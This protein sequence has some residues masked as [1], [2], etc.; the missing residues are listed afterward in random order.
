MIWTRDERARMPRL[1]TTSPHLG[2]RRGRNKDHG[3]IRIHIASHN[4]RTLST[5][6]LLDIYL[7]QME[8]IKADIVGVCETRRARAVSAKWLSGEEI[9]LGEGADNVSRTG[10]VGFIVKAKMAPYV[11]SCDIQS[12][13]VAILKTKLQKLGGSN[14]QNRGGDFNAV[15][16][17]RL[18]GM[19]HLLGRYGVGVRNERGSRLIEFAEQHKF[20][21]M[22]TFFEK[23]SQASLDLEEPG[24]ENFKTD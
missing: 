13:R 7:Q 1:C 19:E 6:S 24:H 15:V 9:L 3:R 11:I 21:I 23:K 20:S 10:G 12:P 17:S 16:G 2:V 4:V 8:K 22:N 18:D 5:D 14:A